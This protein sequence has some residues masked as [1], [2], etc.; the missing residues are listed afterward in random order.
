MEFFADCAKSNWT[1]YQYSVSR[2]GENVNCQLEGDSV[3][4]NFEC[5]YRKIKLVM[6]K[7]VETPNSTIKKFEGICIDQ[8]FQIE[9]DIQFDILENG[10]R[11][12]ARVNRELGG[13]KWILIKDTDSNSYS[14]C[15]LL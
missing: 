8:N 9:R 11:F 5:S 14:S 13:G 1:F 6:N 7:L 4:F 10:A 15:T 3:I 2:N 12:E